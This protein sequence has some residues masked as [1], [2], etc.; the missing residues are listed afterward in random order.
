MPQSSHEAV[1][2]ETRQ[3]VRDQLD[4]F[5][6]DNDQKVA[7]DTDD[8][9]DHDYIYVPG[10]VLMTEGEVEDAFLNALSTRS[11]LPDAAD[12][13]SDRGLG[14]GLV[15]YALPEFSG[16]Q[17]RDVRITVSVMADEVG[18]GKVTAEHFVHLA[19]NGTG[20]ACPATEPAETGLA[21]A[22][23]G[24]I[25]TSDGDGIV[26]AVVDTGWR[27]DQPVGP[28]PRELAEY[29]GHGSF[30][31]EV[32]LVQA[33]AAT[34]KRVPFGM[35]HGGIPEGELSR[36]LR[37]A[38]EEDPTPHVI[39]MSAGCN[40]S[41]N[42]PLL[43]LEQLWADMKD[44][45][46]ETVLIAAAGNEGSPVPFYPA[47]STWATGVGSLDRTDQVSSFSN[48]GVNADVFILGRN[49]INRFPDGRYRCQWTPD[50]DDERLFSTGWARWSGTS[51]ATPLLS[52][53]VAA[54]ISSE[55]SAGSTLT[56]PQLTQQLLGSPMVGW[57]H[58]AT[59][60]DYRFVS[61]RNF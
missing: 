14:S 35:N 28:E 2:L 22:W 42:L 26:V 45:L 58:H 47:A 8:A 53:L 40:T 57:G 3:M 27:E 20:R 11:E 33:P 61:T 48:Y 29:D 6:S 18:K 49:H 31:E 59:Y 24:R 43:A 55:R 23:P 13:E 60:G 34:I 52:G 12:R 4:A 16:D 54:H 51:F 44:Q 37:A 7:W 32:V 10:R 5:R 17:A 9:A 15:S 41:D 39:T 46:H 1:D 56:V 19:T 36:A 30:A 38:I 21:E 50:L 25:T